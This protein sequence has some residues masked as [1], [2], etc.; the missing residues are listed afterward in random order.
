MIRISLAVLLLVGLCGAGSAQ[1]RSARANYILRCAGCHGMTGEGT[2][3]GGVPGFPG[4]VGQIAATE[5][6][7][8]Y[9]MHVPGVVASSLSD[10]EI[11]EVM[12]YVLGTW[13]DSAQLY[14]VEEVR[15]RRATPIGDLIDYRRNMVEALAAEGI[16]IAPYPWP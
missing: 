14:T 7:R 5:T 16:E 15:R 9:M 13:S 4:S 6:G 11:A 8:T 2:V 3:Q 10:T 12:N 1:E